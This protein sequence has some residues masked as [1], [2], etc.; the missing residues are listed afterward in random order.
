M[1]SYSARNNSVPRTFSKHRRFSLRNFSALWFTV[2]IPVFSVLWDTKNFLTELW[3]HQPSPWA[4]LCMTIFDT[5]RFLNYRCVPLRDLSLVLKK[6]STVNGEIPFWCIKISIPEIFRNTERL[7]GYTTK[8]IGTMRHKK[9]SEKPLMLPRPSMREIF[10][11]NISSNQRKALIRFS[12]AL[13]DKKC[14][15]KTR[16]TPIL[17]M[18]FIWYP[19]NFETTKCSPMFFLLLWDKNFWQNRDALLLCTKILVQGTFSK[20]RMVPLRIFLALWNENMST[21]SR[22]AVPRSPPAIILFPYQKASETTKGSRMKFF[23]AVRQKFF[24]KLVIFPPMHQ[25]FMYQIF[26]EMQKGSPTSFLVVMRHKKI[27]DRTVMSPPLPPG[28]P[29]HDNFRH[30]KFFEIQICSPTIFIVSVKK[31][32]NGEWWNPLLMHKKFHTWSFPK[33]RTVKRLHDEVNRYYETQK[34]SEKPVMLPRPSMRENF[35]YKIFLESE[36]CS[37]TIFYGTMRWKTFDRKS[38]YTHNMHEIYSIPENFW[39]T[40]VF[41][42]V[43]FYYLWDKNFWQNRDALPAPIHDSVLYQIFLEIP[44][45]YLTNFFGTVILFVFDGKLR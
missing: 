38:S 18:K 15:T 9:K 44:M 6:I 41:S 3:C 22:D 37:H 19:K 8:F 12:T 43:V 40:E 26:F 24:E 42:I 10:R 34:K 45:C 27:F 21:E 5:R 1:P 36:K 31:K 11:Y 29:M 25:N 20:H 7:N 35:R 4:F 17:C 23:S 13:W 14:S 28:L 32:F 16:D 30:Q 33:Y 2:R 39:N